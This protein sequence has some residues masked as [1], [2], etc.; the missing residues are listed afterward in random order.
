MYHVLDVGFRRFYRLPEPGQS[1]SY[2]IH[3]CWSPVG[4]RVWEKIGARLQEMMNDGFKLKKR[5]ST[6]SNQ[7]DT[8]L[9]ST[10]YNLNILSF[11][12]IFSVIFIRI[13]KKSR[14]YLLY[15]LFKGG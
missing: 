6:T 7:I 10:L 3:W 2:T 9:K 11:N 14:I 12:S 8:P 5:F 15:L 4:S 1:I 13:L